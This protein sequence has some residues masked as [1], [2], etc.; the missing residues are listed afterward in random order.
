MESPFLPGES[1]DP[2]RGH[3]DPVTN[4]LSYCQYKD[5]E[6]R[7]PRSLRV[8]TDGSA[9][10]GIT[11]LGAAIFYPDH[12]QT[13]CVPLGSG[14]NNT[15][16]LE[17]IYKSLSQILEA[18]VNY[19]TPNLP[20]HIFTDSKYAQQTLL[21]NTV[22]RKNFH[23][24]EDIKNLASRLRFDFDMPV[25]IHWIPSHIEKTIYG[26]R[27]IKG[28]HLADQLAEDARA[29]SDE[30]DAHNQTSFVRM[31]IQESVTCLLRGIETLLSPNDDDTLN[32]DGPSPQGDDFD[33]HV[34]ASQ[35]LQSS[36]DT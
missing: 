15:A 3:K 9:R 36:C 29:M 25:S 27:P 2:T 13:T 24:I 11:G 6:S 34:D 7:L 14:T 20:I 23:L 21:N 18:R 26:N 22:G 35:E 8:Y 1:V 33:D 12:E 4:W 17:A 5:I 30:L 19:I 10:D 16:E 28:N 31:K 32:P